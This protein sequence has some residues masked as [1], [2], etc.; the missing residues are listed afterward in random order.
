MKRRFIEHLQTPW[1][2]IHL[3][4]MHVVLDVYAVTWKISSNRMWFKTWTAAPEEK[5]KLHKVQK[6]K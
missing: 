4:L 3:N 1:Q 6:S 5:H 2:S